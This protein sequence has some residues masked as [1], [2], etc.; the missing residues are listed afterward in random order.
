MLRGP[1]E[2]LVP[3][4]REARVSADS[5]LWRAGDPGEGV[6]VLLE[7]TLEVTHPSPEGDEVVL[8]TVEPG[9]I[10]G[11]IASLDGRGR[12]AAVKAATPCRVLHIDT[13]AFREHMRQHPDVLE[14]LFWVQVER[15]RSLTEEVV[16]LHR[17]S[18]VD[19][20]TRLYTGAFF[21]DRLRTELWR[22]RESN[23]PV[24]VVVFGL[25]GLPAF[26]EAGGATR[27]NEILARAA[28]VLLACAR[29]GD[30]VARYG[31]ETFAILL[32][33]AEAEAA[34]RFAEKFRDR[35]GETALPGPGPGRL[36]ASAGL[37]TS[38]RDGVRVDQILDMAETELAEAQEVG[39]GRIGA[40]GER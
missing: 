20:L 1:F 39:A 37:S 15:V 18:I 14:A 31:A 32:Y 10:L 16:R 6:V 30:I 28:E 27:L 5:L 24:S 23:D 4:G 29:R 33:G 25:E 8:R 17:R 9:A 12:T 26:R 22:A 36:T 3:L 11:E 40:P 19:R 35:L 34:F 38:P 21:R 13:A 2:A 7:G